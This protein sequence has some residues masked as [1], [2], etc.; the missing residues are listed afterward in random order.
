MNT[1]I[2]SGRATQRVPLHS[3]VPLEAPFTVGISPSEVCNFK[4]VY[5]AWGTPEGVPGATVLPWD[6]FVNIAGQVKQ[7]YEKAGV[8]CKNLRLHRNG[9]PLINPRIA[10]MVAHI[11]DLGFAERIE[12]TT[13]ASLLTP[14]LS[15]ALLDAGLTRLLVSTQGL[16]SERYQEVCGCNI[17]FEQLMANI[18]YFYDASRNSS[19]QCK[20]HVKTLN[21]AL[22]S[23]EHSRFYETFGHICDTMNIDNVMD[24]D[25][26][27]D[28]NQ[29]HEYS[30]E[31]TRYG[32]S[33]IHRSCCDTLFFVLNIL[34]NGEADCCGCKFPP[35]VI[36]NVFI[37]PL[38]EIWNRGQ[39]K[40]DM[41][42]HLHRQRHTLQ[43]CANCSSLLQ[44]SAPEDNLDGYEEVILQRL[45]RQEDL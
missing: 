29:F 35:H 37:K 28:Y 18:K 23:E 22:S 21:L 36:G 43:K 30:K 7:L 13:N 19:Q 8:K 6:N 15:D 41:I 12:I 45:L 2:T 4:C 40:A 25:G 27:V 33:F 1:K 34:P 10:N 3:V 44:Y 38:I 5:C 24:T 17:D 9:E 14:Q 31:T 16:S 26:T 11:R 20:L 42:T 39:H 32:T